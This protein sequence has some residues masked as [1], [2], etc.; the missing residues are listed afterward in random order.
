MT[1]AGADPDR[2]PRP[3]GPP[4]R[5]RRPTGAGGG[6]GLPWPISAGGC[7]PKGAA[8]RASPAGPG[9]SAGAGGRNADGWVGR[10]P[11]A[12]APGR[13][14]GC[15]LARIERPAARRA[16]A[17][18]GAK[19]RRGQGGGGLPSLG[20]W[21]PAPPAPTPSHEGR[22]DRVRHG[23]RA[24]RGHPGWHVGSASIRD[25]GAGAGA[26]PAA[27]RVGRVPSDPDIS[28]VKGWSAAR[29]ALP[30]GRRAGAAWRGDA[31]HGRDDGESAGLF[32]RAAC[33]GTVRGL[34][35]RLRG[36]GAWGG[37]R[38]VHRS[39]RIG[40]GGGRGI[41]G[42]LLV[43]PSRLLLLDRAGRARQPWRARAGGRT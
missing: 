20:R 2:T 27:G 30:I 23:W 10:V 22:G 4:G 8:R 15:G 18:A 41:R 3:R 36:V 14:R 29:R 39:R 42:R 35:L 9:R 12:F 17:R 19:A 34:P 21:P 5:V 37:P 13:G 32:E 25:G 28:S 6:R 1:S 43:E 31:R 38:A 33:V 7:G 24:R 26:F 40:R 11:L 16:G